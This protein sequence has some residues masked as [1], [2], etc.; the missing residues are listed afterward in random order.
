VSSPSALHRA[1]ERTVLACLCAVFVAASGIAYGYSLQDALGPGSGFFP[2]W[3]GLIGAALSLFLLVQSWRGRAIGD[4]A[5]GVWPDRA[6]ALRSVVLLGGLALAA[7]L[8][9][10]AGFRVTAFVVTGGL[11]VALGVRRPLVIAAFALVASAGL[12]HVFYHWLKVPLPVGPF[13]F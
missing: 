11:L 2:F 1:V 8:L 10:P 7:L 12:F 3:L 5:E 9:V 13:G 6:G 4:G